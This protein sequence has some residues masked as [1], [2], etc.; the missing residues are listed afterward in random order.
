MIYSSLILS[1]EIVY[2]YNN[3]GWED[4]Q[5]ISGDAL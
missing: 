3:F 4:M 1:K 5:G 2:N